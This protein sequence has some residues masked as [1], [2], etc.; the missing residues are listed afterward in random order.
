MKIFRKLILSVLSLVAVVI[1]FASTTYAWF[2]VNSEANVTGFD[3]TAISGEGF[4][5]S[6]DGVNYSNDLTTKQMQMAMIQGYNPERYVIENNTLKE[7]TGDTKVELSSDKMNEI[8]TNTILLSPVTSKNGLDFA[9]LTGSKVQKTSGKYI[10]FDIY[11]KATSNVVEDQL[12]YD[13]YLCGEDLTQM[14]GTVVKKTRIQS[15]AVN[16]ILLL[17][18]MVVYDGTS[19]GKLLGPEKEQNYIDVYT[20][21]AL[22][23]SIQDTSLEEPQ[24]TIYELTNEYDLG[25]YATNYNKETDASDLTD[26]Q[27]EELNKLYNSNYNAMFT[28]YNNLRPYSQLTAMNYEN[29]PKTVRTLDDELVLT[30][31][32]SGGPT[33]KLT[34]RFWL[35]GWDAD[36]FDGLSESINVRLLFNSK[37]NNN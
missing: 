4:L 9:N 12:G 1:C 29:K 24:A 7:I 25:S 8:L 19:N 10:E 28:Y 26:A 2:D 15:K 20:S 18:D 31:V 14:D 21:N 6:V 34:F 23:F 3:F 36:C 5:V 13:I 33:K 11:F 30:H 27:K 32:Q 16:T 35:E 37:F 17:D 22:R